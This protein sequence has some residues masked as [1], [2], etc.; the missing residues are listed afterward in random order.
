MPKGL[1][2]KNVTID[3][4]WTCSNEGDY[5]LKN[6]E[7][8]PPVLGV[9]IAALDGHLVV[10]GIDSLPRSRRRKLLKLPATWKKCSN[11]LSYNHAQICS[12]FSV[13]KAVPS[14]STGTTV[15][16]L[17]KLLSMCSNEHI[18][19]QNFRMKWF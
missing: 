16:F 10:Y 2:D 9:E 19:I 3:L 8:W 1:I 11:R 12:G 17:E 18:S 4:S 6:L 14:G 13:D 7:R 15:E 5:F